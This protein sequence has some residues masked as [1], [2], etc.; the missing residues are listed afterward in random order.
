MTSKST[1]EKKDDEI[2]IFCFLFSPILNK[3]NDDYKAGLA[4][5]DSQ[6]DIMWWDQ[7]YGM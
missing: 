2:G 3:M 6:Q 5:H 4:T 7:N 1:K